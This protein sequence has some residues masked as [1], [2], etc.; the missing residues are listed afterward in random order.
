MEYYSKLFF[1]KDP[2]KQ[3]TRS[4]YWRKCKKGFRSPFLRSW[5]AKPPGKRF[6]PPSRNGSTSSIGLSGTGIPPG[7]RGTAALARKVQDYHEVLRHLI[8]RPMLEF[9][10]SQIGPSADFRRRPLDANF[11]IAIANSRVA[12]RGEKERHEEPSVE[13]SDLA[14]HQR[15]GP[16]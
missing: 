16:D 2:S 13:T 9:F 8:C 10:R 15:P 7:R 4:S 6:R 11:A 3:R 1:C 5:A 14:R 12:G